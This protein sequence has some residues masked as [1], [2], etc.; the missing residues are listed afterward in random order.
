MDIQQIMTRCRKVGET[1]LAAWGGEWETADIVEKEI[2]AA[3]LWGAVR[4]AAESAGGPE[5]ADVI[6]A[7]TMTRLLGLSPAEGAERC[8]YLRSPAAKTHPLLAAAIRGGERIAG[9]RDD[10]D[11]VGSVLRGVVTLAR[12]ESERA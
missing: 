6:A 10:P 5:G 12:R 8:A 7:Q 1:L 2:L 3:F 9:G 11:R 4:A